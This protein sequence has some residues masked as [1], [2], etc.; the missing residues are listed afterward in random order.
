MLQPYHS[1]LSHQG[2]SYPRR[3]ILPTGNNFGGSDL[4]TL[5]S[6]R[7]TRSAIVSSFVLLTQKSS[8][9]LLQLFSLILV[10]IW[11]WCLLAAVGI[12]LR[13]ESKIDTITRKTEGVP[14]KST[15]T[16]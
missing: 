1:K 14:V 16:A 4:N 8:E 3:Q 10:S 5:P 9:L 13:C 15:P 2:S 6:P 7:F 11:F 12:I